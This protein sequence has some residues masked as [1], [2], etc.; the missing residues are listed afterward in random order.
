[1]RQL[2]A[3]LAVTLCRISLVAAY[4][5][6]RQSIPNGGADRLPASAGHKKTAGGGSLNMFGADFKSQ[7][8]KWTVALCKMDSDGDGVSN[9]A[10]LGDPDCKWKAGDPQPTCAKPSHPGVNQAGQ[11]VPCGDPS[12]SV[13]AV[14][15]K[16]TGAVLLAHGFMMLLA[17]VVV[18][19]FGTSA[20]IYG[21][22]GFHRGPLHFKIHKFAM[23]GGLSL[24]WVAV[25]VAIVICQKD[26]VSLGFHGAAGLLIMLAGTVQA[27]SSRFRGPKPTNADGSNKHAPLRSWRG[28]HVRFGQ[29]IVPLSF[30][31]CITGALT[32]RSH[33]TVDQ[34]WAMPALTFALVFL[35]LLGM[36]I[37]WVMNGFG[38]HGQIKVGMQSQPM[39]TEAG[40]GKTAP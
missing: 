32:Y 7:G 19:G 20:A 35:S 18:M 24:A 40:V 39:S 21:E 2:H 17:W 30:F 38:M 6:Y 4:P 26:D 36:T 31:V 5:S 9:G 25:I 1:M 12:V 14:E 34:S 3:L 33:W 28:F 22:P 8:N 23:A 27:V 13:L 15:E 11:N 16:N 37:A 10:E 29:A